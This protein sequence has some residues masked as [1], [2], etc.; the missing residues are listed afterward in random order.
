MKVD[1]IEEVSATTRKVRDHLVC[2]LCGTASAAG[3]YWHGDAQ[4]NDTTVCMEVGN[5]YGPGGGDKKTTEFDICPTCFSTK[6][7][8][9]LESQGAKPRTEE[10]DW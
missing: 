3:G 8:P 7:M 10:R 9:W 6:L 2:D 5:S 1:R 4:T